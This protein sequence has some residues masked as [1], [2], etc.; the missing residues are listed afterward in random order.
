MEIIQSH[1]CFGGVLHI[2]EHSSDALKGGMRF[3]IFLPP[4]AAHDTPV[5]YITFLSGLTCTHENFTTKAGAYAAAASLGLAI[6]A[7]DTSPRADDAADDAAAHDLGKGAG[8]YIDATQTPWASHYRMEHYI[9]HELAAM[10]PA[11][12]PVK[13]DA[14]GIMGHS[15]GGHG[16]LTLFF[17]YP[18]LYRCA[19]DLC[20]DCRAVASAVGA[21]GVHAL[22]RR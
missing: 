11:A 14:Q 1:R 7:P 22:S 3:S 4:A 12:F 20:P 13:R 10:I 21:K 18:H 5:P 16:A 15:M 8:F 19:S 9:A 6:L 17:K 2:C